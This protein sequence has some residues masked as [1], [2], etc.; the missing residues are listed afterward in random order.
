MSKMLN[1]K[2]MPSHKR[3]L[4]PF[5][6]VMFFLLACYCAAIITVFIWSLLSSFKTELDIFNN[7]WGLDANWNIDA[8][9]KVFNELADKKYVN[10][11]LKHVF[12]EEMFLN[13]LLYST[14]GALAVTFCTAVVA[15]CTAKY[16]GVVSTII[17]YVVVV[18]I[19]F[20]IVGNLASML[21]VTKVLKL[22]DNIVGLWIMKFGFNNLYYFIFYAAFDKVSWEYA[23]AAFIDGASHFRVFFKVMLPLVKNLFLTVFLLNFIYCWNDFETAYMYLPNHPTVSVILYTAINSGGSLVK[24]IDTPTQ[25]ATA[26]MVF[27]PILVL[28]CIFKDKIMSNL[29]E[30]GLKG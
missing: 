30:G 2:A 25:I 17:Y 4:K 9:K 16:K 5:E 10:G 20:P 26:V 7:P 27:L 1:E 3:K 15:Y 8:W 6:G 23:E 11:E 12:F 22:Y 18:T 14:G 28:F 13:S 29:T 21:S 24:P 19:I